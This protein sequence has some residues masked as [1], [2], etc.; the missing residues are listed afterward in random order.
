MY[1]TASSPTL[2]RTISEL[3]Q[4][5]K[6]KATEEDPERLGSGFSTVRS[7][8]GPCA[9]ISDI[10]RVYNSLKAVLVSP[11]VSQAPPPV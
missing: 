4:E 10:L 1:V 3:Q 2:T 9:P 8:P 6:E 7:S 11:G 5:R